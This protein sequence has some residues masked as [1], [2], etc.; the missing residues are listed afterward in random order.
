MKNSKDDV[1]LG[2]RETPSQT[3][4]LILY[5]GCCLSLCLG[6][7]LSKHMICMENIVSLF[8]FAESTFW[9][10]ALVLRLLLLAEATL[11]CYEVASK[12]FSRQ[13]FINSRSEEWVQRR[14]R[15]KR[16]LKKWIRDFSIFIAII[17]AWNWI[18]KSHILKFRNRKKILK[19]RLIIFF[20]SDLL[21]DRIFWFV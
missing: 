6:Q 1:E 17:P 8:I 4:W 16:P 14:R 19:K 9:R 5:K 11:S 18:P 21:W 3:R 13:P 20:Q 7:I 2:R 10:T 15:R 12:N